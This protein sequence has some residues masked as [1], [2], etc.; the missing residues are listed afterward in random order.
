MTNSVRQILIQITF[1]VMSVRKPLL[2]T[3]ALKRLGVTIIF[4]HDY[5]H[6]IFRN[7]MVNLVSHDCHSY[8]HITL[9]NGKMVMTGENAANDVDEEVSRAIE[10]TSSGERGKAGKLRRITRGDCGLLEEQTH[11]Q[12]D[13]SRKHT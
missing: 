9:A 5:D 1:D 2:S 7:E 6:I 8:P 12:D 10:D 3:P 13:L 4:N 11:L